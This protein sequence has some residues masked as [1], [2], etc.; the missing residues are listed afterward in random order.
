MTASLA[1]DAEIAAGLAPFDSMRKNST[2]PNPKL[3]EQMRELVP[4]SAI[5]LVNRLS[6]SG[7]VIAESRIK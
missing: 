3:R 5:D 4:K 1:G 6:G 7:P 2:T